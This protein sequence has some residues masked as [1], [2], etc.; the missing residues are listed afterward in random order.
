MQTLSG[1]SVLFY[2]NE[3]FYY[4]CNILID[5][6]AIFWIFYAPGTK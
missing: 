5:E 2:Q 3:I 6:F 4:S 1:V